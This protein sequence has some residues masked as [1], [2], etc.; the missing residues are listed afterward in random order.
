MK[1]INVTIP[2]SMAENFVSVLLKEKLIACGTIVPGVKSHYWWKG[3]ITLADEA[4]LMMKTADDVYPTLMDRMREL[5]PYE[6][7]EIVTSEP[8]DVNP[9]YDAWVR[10]STHGSHRPT[11]TAEMLDEL[12]EQGTAP[13]PVVEIA[14]DE[15][16]AQPVS[17]MAIVLIGPPGSGRNTQAR[18]LADKYAMT[19]I[20][21]G[22][23][24]TEEAAKDTKR[25]AR[26][27][28]KMATGVLA[29]DSDVNAV[30]GSAIKAT[31]GGLILEGYP[32]T[33]AQAEALEAVRMPDVVIYLSADQDALM[34]RIASRLVCNE[35]GRSYG[36]DS[37]PKH[38]GICDED[39]YKLRPRE[40]DSPDIVE[41]RLR[42]YNE[43]TRPLLSRYREILK[44]VPSEGGIEAV[45]EKICLALEESA[46]DM[47]T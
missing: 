37:P 46:H 45:H 16:A 5:H 38:P 23:F 32:G 9:A 10:E 18:K 24:L 29:N 28:T 14:V 6:I 27:R 25:G 31:E 11:G 3:S 47:A 42:E 35:C 19:S 33:E 34:E 26:I 1:L 36:A 7:P 17:S 20:G 12:A 13:G 41:E 22:T 8:D 15:A 44:H 4:L 39:G 2:E 30:L 21:C 43:K 40:D